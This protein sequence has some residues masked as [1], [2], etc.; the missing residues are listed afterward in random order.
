MSTLHAP[1][2]FDARSWRIIKECAGIYG[3]LTPTELQAIRDLSREQFNAILDSVD[4]DD[5]TLGF[6]IKKWSRKK[7][8]DWSKRWASLYYDIN[9]PGDVAEM[10]RIQIRLRMI[11]MNQSTHP[12]VFMP[13]ID[14]A[15][16]TEKSTISEIDWLLGTQV[17][18]ETIA[19]YFNEQTKK[20]TRLRQKMA[21]HPKREAI[22]KALKLGLKNQPR[23]VRGGIC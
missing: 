7:C 21:T 23:S 18:D 10:R 14:K 13:P 16:I 12:S 1:H 6:P 20:N 15:K 2:R 22:Y 4:S 19:D 8:Y 9:H 3:I 11:P 5:F 17:T